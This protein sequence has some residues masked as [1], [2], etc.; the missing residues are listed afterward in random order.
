MERLDE[1]RRLAA[2]PDLT[3]E[4]RQAL[5]HFDEK[6]QEADLR[7]ENHDTMYRDFGRAYARLQHERGLGKPVL[8]PEEHKERRELALSVL[9][10]QQ[11]QRERPSDPYLPL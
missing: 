7:A 5:Q 8:S 2:K 11:S 10:D 6:C 4:D 3:D 1:R 9:R